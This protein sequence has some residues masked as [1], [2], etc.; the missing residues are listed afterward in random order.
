MVRRIVQRTRGH[1]YD[2]D[3]D[4]LE[5][6]FEQ[7]EIEEIH[8]AEQVT[9]DGIP[10]HFF[11]SVESSM[12]LALLEYR[13]HRADTD[14]EKHRVDKETEKYCV[15]KETEKHLADKDTE[16]TKYITEA[17]IAE[18]KASVDLV[19]AQNE[20]IKLKHSLG[21]FTEIPR[22]KRP[23]VAP[24]TLDDPAVRQW[25]QRY[26]VS[27][28]VRDAVAPNHP[29]AEVFHGVHAWFEARHNRVGFRKLDVRVRT[30]SD[31]PVVYG[32]PR[33]TPRAFGGTTQYDQLVRHIRHTV[34][35]EDDTTSTS[36]GTEDVPSVVTDND[37]VVTQRQRRSP[38]PFFEPT[39]VEPVSEAQQENDIWL[40]CRLAGV[41]YE[42]WPTRPM[43]DV[44]PNP[45]DWSRMAPRARRRAKDMVHAMGWTEAVDVGYYMLIV[46]ARRL[47]GWR[48]TN[49]NDGYVKE[50]GRWIRRVLLATRGL[51]KDHPVAANLC[52][53]LGVSTGYLP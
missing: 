37:P 35:K 15:D 53:A 31:L 14:V 44:A 5:E 49:V 24:L 8:P 28:E 6:T 32:W 10:V 39:P 22:S 26:S 21:E 25:G 23:K 7:L 40:F 51:T 30:V 38:A 50:A 16:K 46:L 41:D 12:L 4:S 47:P 33:G 52:V 18:A 34:L 27:H 42:D 36:H 43:T 45:T 9:I 13:K 11:T 1:R 48:F 29:I 20:Q 17:R 3:S 2:P 19:L